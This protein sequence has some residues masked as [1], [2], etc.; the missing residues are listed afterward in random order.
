MS[1]LAKKLESV[2][3]EIRSLLLSAPVGLTVRELTN[4]FSEFLGKPLPWRQLNYNNAEEFLHDMPD[5]VEISWNGSTMVLKGVSDKSTAH[6][7]KLVSNQKVDTKKKWGALGRNKREQNFSGSQGNRRTFSGSSRSGNIMQRSR[8]SSTYHH[9]SS[10]SGDW[11]NSSRPQRF[12][13]SSYII[14]MT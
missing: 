5:T 13:S 8:M 2:K 3:K 14:I 4:D 11:R 10:S 12:A 1:E 9:N 6:I 7:K